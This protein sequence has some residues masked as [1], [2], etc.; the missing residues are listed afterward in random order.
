VH[1]GVVESSFAS[2]VELALEKSDPRG[3]GPARLVLQAPR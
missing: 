2:A 1:S 3:V